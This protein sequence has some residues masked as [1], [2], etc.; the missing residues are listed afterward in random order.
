MLALFRLVN[1]YVA[2]LHPMPG[3]FPNY[4]APAIRNTEAATEM[5]LGH[6]FSPRVASRQLGGA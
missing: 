1:R 5:M 2:N 4:A 6:H 3:V